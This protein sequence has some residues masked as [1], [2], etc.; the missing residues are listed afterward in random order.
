MKTNSISFGRAIRMQGPK[1]VAEQIKV[2]VNKKQYSQ[3]GKALKEF[4]MPIF[5]D[6]NALGGGIEVF[7]LSSDKHY[8]FSGEEAKKA[9][10]II[11]NARYTCTKNINDANRSATTQEQRD[12]YTRIA[13]EEN[14]RIN[15]RRDERLK[16]LLDGNPKNPN[17]SFIL[18]QSYEEYNDNGAI[19]QRGVIN[20]CSMSKQV[21]HE[22]T[23]RFEA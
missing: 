1:R 10:E 11:E 18:V 6:A 13:T 4:A 3:S 8:L 9:R 7:S 5:Y 12:K 19:K 2:A 15:K 16:E 20:Y 21:T 17:N 23:F 22:S 14:D